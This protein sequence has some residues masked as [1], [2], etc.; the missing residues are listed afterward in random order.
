MTAHRNNGCSRLYRAGTRNA[1]S[2]ISLIEVLFA[3]SIIA[4]VVIGLSGASLRSFVAVER[5]K[6]AR[7]AALLAS[8][9]LTREQQKGNGQFYQIQSGNGS[10]QFTYYVAD[11]PS[12]FTYYYVIDVQLMKGSNVDGV[13]RVKVRIY[14]KEQGKAKFI[15]L[16]TICSAMG[17]GMKMLRSRKR[18]GF[19]LAEVSVAG[20]LA[21][22]VCYCCYM[23][24]GPMMAFQ[25]GTDVQIDIQ[26]N[27]EFCVWKICRELKETEGA[28][29][30]NNTGS[31]LC[32]FSYLSARDRLN[33][34]RLEPN[35]L[36]CL[37]QKYVIY[38]I[39]AGKD[40]LLR[41]EVYLSTPATESRR[42][43]SMELASYCDGSGVVVGRGIAG[44]LIS[45]SVP[46]SSPLF[47]VS[48]QRLAGG[49][50]H[51]FTAQSGFNFYVREQ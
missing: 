41:K 4:V 16:Y 19:S 36:R 22:V 44:M 8:Q 28:G 23:L 39:P 43:T 2:G 31:A 37:W 35:S 5:G 21:L 49:K 20:S 11:K 1:C 42:L 47:T 34:F 17:L 24:M 30:T 15:E 45:S 3:L 48:A 27:A 18:A 10:V 14:W 32:A 12:T 40:N 9:L 7:Q 26:E 25:D 6:N 13:K 46:G 38:Y 50:V 51:N 33:V 29:F